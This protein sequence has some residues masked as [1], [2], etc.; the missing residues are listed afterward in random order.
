MEGKDHVRGS[1]CLLDHHVGRLHPEPELVV[2]FTDGEGA[3]ADLWV[4]RL[5]IQN[6]VSYVKCEM[7]TDCHVQASSRQLDV[8]R[9]AL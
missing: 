3:K 6:S 7:S 2:P 4:Q 1:G 8:L 9:V 5:G